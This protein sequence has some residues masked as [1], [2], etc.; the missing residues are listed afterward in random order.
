[1]STPLKSTLNIHEAILS[2]KVENVNQYLTTNPSYPLEA[3]DK[4]GSRP[5]HY[6]NSVDMVKLLIDKGANIDSVTANNST[7]LHLAI[8]RNEKELIRFLVEREASLNGEDVFGK[9]PL[10][11]AIQSKQADVVQLLLEHGAL[12]M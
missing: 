10:I 7:L 11:Y 12:S 9:T 3:I 5:L 4:F 6:V 1:L 8:Q 2:D